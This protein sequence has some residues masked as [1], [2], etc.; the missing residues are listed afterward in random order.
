MKFLI[1]ADRAR[2]LDK[3]R[4]VVDAFARAIREAR[5]DLHAAGDP[6]AL[7]KPLTMLLFGM[8]NW[9]FTWLRPDGALSHRDMAPVVADLFLGGLGAVAALPRARAA[10]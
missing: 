8:M 5:P 2:V 7:A 6:A 9:M 4:Q 10:A 1:D 3:E